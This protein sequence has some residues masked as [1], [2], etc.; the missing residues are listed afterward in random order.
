MIRYTY[1]HT[2]FFLMYSRTVGF[3]FKNRNSVAM[4]K[5][6]RSPGLLFILK[7]TMYFL[8]LI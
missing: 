2:Y 1:V 6:K 5:Y 8:K 3:S 4:A 7:N